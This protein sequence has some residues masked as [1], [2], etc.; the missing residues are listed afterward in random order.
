MPP[1]AFTNPAPLT[2]S[3]REA[4]KNFF[5]E[6]CNKGYKRHNEFEAHI[7]SYDHQHKKRLKDMK[8]M[9]KNP[10]AA[11]KARRAERKADEEA[12]LIS[13]DPVKLDLP[14]S[15][16]GGFKK[17]GFKSAF[18]KAAAPAV[19]EQAQQQQQ[20]ATTDAPTPPVP[21]KGGFKKAFGGGGAEEK[22]SDD[23]AK[24]VKGLA[25][26]EII[27]DV[28]DETDSDEDLGYPK[29]DPSRPTGCRDP[30]CHCHDI[31][32]PPQTIFPK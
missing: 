24:E 14:P 3:A 23:F 25:P 32:S 8:E 21:A 19:D 4:A 5:C 27:D 30:G 9:S 26:A 6:L 7:S 28:D 13:M 22:K 11:E 29:Y 1:R 10:Q 2:D 15:K 31:S 16:K 18:G 17:G 12:G 20:Q